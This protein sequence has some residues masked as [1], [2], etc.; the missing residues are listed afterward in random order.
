MSSAVPTGLALGVDESPGTEVPGY[1]H[2][3]L[4]G[5]QNRPRADRDGAMDSK[6]FYEPQSYGQRFV[7][8]GTKRE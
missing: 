1:S 8:S 6:L 7:P 4:T 2:R 3:V 5:T